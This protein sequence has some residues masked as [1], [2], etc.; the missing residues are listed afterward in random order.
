MTANFPEL[1]HLSFLFV[2]FDLCM[3]SN[4]TLAVCDPSFVF[5]SESPL[6]SYPCLS[7]Y[8]RP[9]PSSDANS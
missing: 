4:K 3:N 6:W 5:T 2:L 8:L 9:A 7:S 1:P